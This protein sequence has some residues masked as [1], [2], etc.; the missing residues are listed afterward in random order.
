MA[1]Q[2]SEIIFHAIPAALVG[3]AFGFVAGF[4]LN[5]PSHGEMLF[6]VASSIFAVVIFCLVWPRREQRQH[7]G[8]F[9]SLQSKLEAVVPAVAG[10]V[11]FVVSTVLF[12]KID[13]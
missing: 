4:G 11:L 12:W 10:P 3:I 8:G 5:S 9:G 6:W 1:I 13:L 7:G 2:W